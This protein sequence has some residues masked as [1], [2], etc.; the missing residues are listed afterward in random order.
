MFNRSRKDMARIVD[1]NTLSS[2]DG[3]EIKMTT[4]KHK[5]DYAAKRIEKLPFLDSGG[6]GL[7]RGVLPKYSVCQKGALRRARVIYF[8]CA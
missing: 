2:D 7:T 8:I 1:N 3:G 5:D 4:T 6:A